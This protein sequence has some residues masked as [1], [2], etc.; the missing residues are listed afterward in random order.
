MS[1]A[2]NSSAAKIS[3]KGFNELFQPT[4]YETQS[5]ERG[6]VVEIPLAQLYEFKNHPF[7]VRDDDEMAMLS[8]SI[9]TNGVLVPAIVRSRT[10]GGYELISGHRRKRGAEI[11][12]LEKLPVV[13]KE[14]SD[15][16]AVI[17]MADANLQREHILPSEKARAYKMKYDAIKHQGQ[18]KDGGDSLEV[19]GNE[20]GD[21]RSSIQRFLRLNNLSDELLS[22]VDNGKIGLVQGVDLSFLSDTEQQ[23]VYETIVENGIRITKDQAAKLKEASANQALSTFVIAMVLQ[24]KKSKKDQF[25]FKKSQIRKYFDASDTDEYIEEVIIQLLEER[26]RNGGRIE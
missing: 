8:E 14:M 25:V 21:S 3:L 22:M 7:L 17:A 2:R 26:C 9:R 11:A 15:D 20:S 18:G 4:D 1:N 13:I 19:L 23:L 5:M 10:E 12:G 24:E 6:K 16:E